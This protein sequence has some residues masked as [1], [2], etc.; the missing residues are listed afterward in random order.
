MTKNKKK[1]YKKRITYTFVSL[2]FT[3]GLAL[4]AQAYTSC[5]GGTVV[6]LHAYDDAA[7]PSECTPT[8]CPKPA[9]SFCRSNIT[10]N[11]WSGFNWCESNGGTLASLQSICPGMMNG[12]TCYPLK[13]KG[14]SEWIWTSTSS[15]EGSAVM[16]NPS[17][18]S[19]VSFGRTKSY[20]VYCE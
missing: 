7:A 9:K 5:E 17:N 14:G 11:W 3:M 20:R 1:I 18:G 16:L 12:G 6:T 19:R 13:G 10:M 2:F 15:G 8:L 4:S